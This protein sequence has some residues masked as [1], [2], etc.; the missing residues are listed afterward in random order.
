MGLRPSTPPPLLPEN[1]RIASRI[2]REDVV[3]ENRYEFNI[4]WGRLVFELQTFM[5]IGSNVA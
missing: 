5:H 4:L 2:S 1:G 3:N